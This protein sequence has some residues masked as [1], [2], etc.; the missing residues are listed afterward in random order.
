MKR[1]FFARHVQLPV[2]LVLVA[3]AW[4]LAFWL[5][6]NL[7]VPDEFE[8]LMVQALPWP[9]LAYGASL[10]GWRVYRHIW[11][12]GDLIVWDNRCSMHARDDFPSD[13][14]RLML[15]TTVNG[16]VRPY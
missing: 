15:R 7:D 6:F 13:Q 4:W 10:L 11:R 9:L 8:A 5:R 3:L 12:V 2:D 14:R 16:T 1:F